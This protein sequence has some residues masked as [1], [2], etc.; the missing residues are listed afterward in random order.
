MR[1]ER[2]ISILLIAASA[3]AAA[4]N[5]QKASA[6]QADNAA[7]R[8][9]IESLE[10]ESAQAVQAAEAAKTSADKLKTQTT[11]LA[12][13]RNEI[14]Q[15]RTSAQTAE[16][17]TSENQRLRAENQ[18]LQG[19]AGA[20]GAAAGGAA[21]NLAGRDHFPRSSWNF[22][23][24]NSPEAAL[25]SAIWAMKEGDPKTYLA[26][27]TPDEQQKAAQ[28]WQ[29]Q[30]KSEA[31]VAEK[32]KNDVAA[33]SGMRVL[34]VQTVSPT[35]TVMSVYLDGPG[36]MEKVRMSQIGQ[37]WKFGGF[38]RDQQPVNAVPLTPAK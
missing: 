8:A 23:G 1:I 37:E 21:E 13:L 14:T 38:M 10:G 3:G 34:E 20:A 11:E 5:W 25:V 29:T 16:A 4:L 28:N 24:Y 22:A 32:H 26:S 19:Q 36:R 17:L 27:L 9:K 15:L 30:N 31:E 18:H 35:E 6:L 7:L 33:I 2:I 12:K